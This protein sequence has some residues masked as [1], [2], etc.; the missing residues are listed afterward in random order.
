[1]GHLSGD[2]H[3]SSETF[4]TYQ[5]GREGNKTGVCGMEMQKRRGWTDKK[6][7]D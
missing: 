5:S 1:M 2:Q 4:D 7:V 3:F 6:K